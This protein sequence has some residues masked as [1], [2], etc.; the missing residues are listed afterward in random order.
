[1]DKTSL[2]E[3]ISKYTQINLT[4]THAIVSELIGV[5]QQTVCN[6]EKVTLQGFGTF[7]TRKRNA[8]SIRSLNG[9]LI[10]IPANQTP[11]FKP[12]QKFKSEIK[13]L[14]TVFGDLKFWNKFYKIRDI[15][16]KVLKKEKLIGKYEF[17]EEN[18]KFMVTLLKYSI[19]ENDLT[20][21]GDKFVF[22][23]LIEICKRWKNDIN[24][25]NTDRGFWQFLTQELT[26]Q[27]KN[28][29][30][31]QHITRFLDKIARAG[32]IIEAQNST[33]K[34]YATLMMHALAPQASLN[35]FFELCFKIF[36]ENLKYRYLKNE[37]YW[38]CEKVGEELRKVFN[39]TEDNA[40]NSVNIG[41]NTYSILIGLRCFVLHNSLRSEFNKFLNNTFVKIH[42][43]YYNEPYK[44]DKRSRQDNLLYKWWQE[45]E[46]ETNVQQSS[47]R[48]HDIL[49]PQSKIYAKYI[50]NSKKNN[51]QLYIPPIVIDSI[52]DNLTTSIYVG[53]RM[54]YSN[55][56]HTRK[57]EIF[58]ETIE[59]KYNLNAF[60]KDSLNKQIDI[61]VIIDLNGEILYDSSEKLF[62]EIILFDG[63]NEIK[64][65]IIPASNYILYSQDIESLNDISNDISTIGNNLYNIYPQVGESIIVGFQ[66]YHIVDKQDFSAWENKDIFLIGGKHDVKWRNSIGNDYM[67]FPSKIKLMIDGS[68]NLNSLE[69]RIDGERC[70]LSFLSYNSI[71]EKNRNYY[72]FELDLIRENKP[73]KIEI[74]S[75]QKNKILL[76]EF[77]MVLNDMAYRFEKKIYYGGMT[78]KLWVSFKG[79]AIIYKFDNV[80]QNLPVPFMKGN[81]LFSVPCFQ[82]R[83]N[84]E[85]WNHSELPEILW[86]KDIL[87]SGDFIDINSPIGEF[88]M[89]LKTSNGNIHSLTLDGNKKYPLGRY[90]YA[91]QKEKEISICAINKTNGEPIEFL[92]F[93]ISTEE[94]FKNV[95]IIQT[96]NSFFWQIENNFIGPVD[97]DFI[98]QVHK[99]DE[100]LDKFSVNNKDCELSYIKELVQ[101]NGVGDY[102]VS[103]LLNE[104]KNVFGKP[105]EL[106]LKKFTI[107]H[108]KTIKYKNQKLQLT[109]VVLSNS[110]EDEVS[111]NSK[112]EIR[113]LKYESDIEDK[114]VYTGQLFKD[115]KEIITMFDENGEK[116]KITPVFIEFIDQSSVYLNPN[117]ME[118]FYFNKEDKTISNRPGNKKS[119]YDYVQQKIVYIEDNSHYHLIEYFKFIMKDV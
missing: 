69:L 31:Y 104:K 71:V 90:V 66:K 72:L 49:V 6:G 28:Q 12:S 81:L 53:G 97:K 20:L 7:T 106:W 61:R 29:K 17:S 88:E 75:Y 11:L 1:M 59:Q 64:S 111:F 38:I 58:I 55:T 36:K 51:V 4:S 79:T 37:D 107:H 45:R 74:Y 115:D 13:Q 87:N 110:N 65:A 96:N 22:C 80:S 91:L 3:K 77:V 117:S 32:L 30:L 15:V 35:S 39:K 63:E 8:R 48:N 43:L 113:N 23:T 95:P 16:N 44:P 27:P 68:F 57:T 98:I 82:W 42:Q 46:D 14:N 112:Y 89:V 60:L 93:R 26:D 2:C 101:R 109:A 24:G 52:E 19:A 25:E 9:D 67:I 116:E 56:P 70:N 99:N 5:I 108:P 40:T 119:G 33:K 114:D 105:K 83:I 34:Y 118:A 18:Y 54:L 85:D 103:V 47:I 62:R 100:I 86:Y 92:L 94:Y 21:L 73:T 102:L 50:L 84:Y 78:I 10:T 76:D 41:A